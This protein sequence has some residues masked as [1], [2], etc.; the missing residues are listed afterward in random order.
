MGRCNHTATLLDN[1]TVLMVAGCSGDSPPQSLYL[2]SA[3]FYEPSAGTFTATGSLTVP[4][5]FHTAAL[6]PGGMVLI[7]GGVS[8]IGDL[9]SAELYNE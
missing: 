9:A 7:A 8:D 3:E 6:L 2:T 1:N 5:E 4:M